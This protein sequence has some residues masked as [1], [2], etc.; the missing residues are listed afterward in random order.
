MRTA[1]DNILN[2]ESHERIYC[3]SG[4]KVEP[5]YHV[6][7]DK[8]G[9]RIL[10]IDGQ[11]NTFDDIQSHRESCDIE[12]ILKRYMAGDFSV[13]NRN[14]PQY[15]DTTEF[16]KSYAEAFEKNQAAKEYFYSLDPEIRAQF[17][18][19]VEQFLVAEV[20]KIFATDKEVIDES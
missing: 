12:I 15:I 7:Y 4:L 5:E 14:D 20:D 10:K 6:H 11:K 19:S 2:P 9:K 1:L 18:N 16:P 3:S 8:D 17:N 13:L